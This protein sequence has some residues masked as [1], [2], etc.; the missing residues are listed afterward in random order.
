[1]KW[2]WLPGGVGGREDANEIRVRFP[3]G[4]EYI[5]LVLVDG[6]GRERVFGL[7]GH[8]MFIELLG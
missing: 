1:M 2:Q 6:L 8:E 3:I 5:L 7:K 4:M